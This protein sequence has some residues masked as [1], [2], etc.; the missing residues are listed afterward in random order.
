M[1]DVLVTPLVILTWLL[2]GWVALGIV[3]VVI[4]M[5]TSLIVGARQDRRISRRIESSRG[6]HG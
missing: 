1:P 2:L 6:R 4:F 3:A 5:V